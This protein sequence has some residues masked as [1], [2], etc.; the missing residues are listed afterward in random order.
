MAKL[1]A[2]QKASTETTGACFRLS[3]SG[4]KPREMASLLWCF[5][6][7]ATRRRLASDVTGGYASKRSMEFEAQSIANLVWYCG[8]LHLQGAEASG[9]LASGGRRHAEQF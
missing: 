6:T 8:V 4:W 2:Q 7:P 3:T 9:A 1:R 5:A